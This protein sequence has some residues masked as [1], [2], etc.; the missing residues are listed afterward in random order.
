ML[1]L[2]ELHSVACGDFSQLFLYIAEFIFSCA[3][4]NL[5]ISDYFSK[6][7]TQKAI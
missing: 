2:G 4:E 6:L 7:L 1:M 5:L 3:L